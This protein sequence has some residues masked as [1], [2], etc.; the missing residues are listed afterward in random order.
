MNLDDIR[1]DARTNQW[2]DGAAC[3][4]S[5]YCASTFITVC[6]T[7]TYF[8]SSEIFQGGRLYTVRC[9]SSETGEIRKASEVGQFASRNG[10]VGWMRRKIKP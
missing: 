2:F 5:R 10:A 9:Y 8:V 7:L 6:D 3:F 4:Q 1:A